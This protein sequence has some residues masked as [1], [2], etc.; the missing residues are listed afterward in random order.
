MGNPLKDKNNLRFDLQ[1]TSESG[2]TKI[3]RVYN[4]HNDFFLGKVQ[5]YAPWRKYCF[6]PAPIE[7]VFDANCLTEIAAYC[8][9]E[10]AVLKVERN[11]E[12]RGMEKR[13]DA[14][15]NK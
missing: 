4:K 9:T 5:W 15:K 13:L 2:K 3:W 10:S 14:K 11:R 12:Q 6:L 7:S 8:A 1:G